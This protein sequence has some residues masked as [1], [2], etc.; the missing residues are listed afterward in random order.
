MVL[1]ARLLDG[2]AGV[3][4]GPGGAPEEEQPRDCPAHRSL[5]DDVA[6]DRHEGGGMGAQLAFFFNHKNILKIADSEMRPKGV[7]SFNLRGIYYP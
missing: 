4:H 1:S 6:G 5:R 2:E 7:M 3:R